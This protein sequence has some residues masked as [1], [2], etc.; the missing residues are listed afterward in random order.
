M[1]WVMALKPDQ[2]PF[3]DKSG[4]YEWHVGD[5]KKALSHMFLLAAWRNC[6]PRYTFWFFHMSAFIILVNSIASGKFS[7]LLPNMA[8]GSIS[9]LAKDVLC[10]A[11]IWVKD[12]QSKKLL[13]KKTKQFA[14]A[15][16][17]LPW[18]L[19]PLLWS[20]KLNFGSRRWDIQ[21]LL[22]KSYLSGFH[23]LHLWTLWKPLQNGHLFKCSKVW[24]GQKKVSLGIILP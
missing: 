19:N 3:V 20:S 9:S 17:L 7:C 21:F 1:T 4:L 12:K 6:H 10:F 18:P 22:V 15:R 24:I 16:I 23:S 5:H 14:R 13:V 2:D 8:A 11:A